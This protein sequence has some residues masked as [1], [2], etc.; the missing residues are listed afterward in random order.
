MDYFLVCCPSLKADQAKKY[1]FD[2]IGSYC[3]T[4]NFSTWSTINRNTP[5]LQK[6]VLDEVENLKA[7]VV[8]NYVNKQFYITNPVKACAGVAI[9]V[10]CFVAGYAMYRYQYVDKKSEDDEL[11]NDEN[12]Q[13]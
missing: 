10:A 7:V 4:R 12:E 9:M 6:A 3:F 11:E 8:P 13:A 1:L 2:D 5:A